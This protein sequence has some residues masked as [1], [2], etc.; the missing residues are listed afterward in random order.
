[1]KYER[2]TDVLYKLTAIYYENK[3]YARYP[4]FKVWRHTYGYFHTLDEAED[5]MRKEVDKYNR[6]LADGLDIYHY[7]GF[8][9]CTIPFNQKLHSRYDTLCT[10]TYIEDGSFLSETKVSNIKSSHYC[11]G[12]EP[13]KGRTVEECR[14]KGGDIVEA[15]DG[16]DTVSLEIVYSPPPTPELAE[17]IYQNVRNDLL[18]RGKEITDNELCWHLDYTDDSYVTLDGDEGYMDN[19]CHR[20]VCEL[21]P[22]RSTVSPKLREKLERGLKKAQNE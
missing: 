22:V 18:R 16:D 5:L 10:R 4:R 17:Q 8:E 15:Y 2:S 19:H 12:Y 1:M 11:R 9:I 13:F 7:Y 14:F 20:Y 6:D 21:F 3:K